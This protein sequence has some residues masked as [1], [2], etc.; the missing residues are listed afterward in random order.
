MK[1]LV[2]LFHR[3][4]LKQALRSSLCA[5]RGAEPWFPSG[6]AAAVL[7]CHFGGGGGSIQIVLEQ[8]Q[9]PPL[10]RLNG[11]EVDDWVQAAVEVHERNC[12]LRGE[13]GRI[14]RSKEVNGKPTGRSSL[15]VRT[16]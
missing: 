12:D 1:R 4:G 10:V 16:P 8:A 5:S 7:S 9:H 11:K 14:T 6:V 2:S 13:R 3:E 15:P